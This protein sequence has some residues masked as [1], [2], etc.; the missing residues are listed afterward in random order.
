[1]NIVELLQI[2]NDSRPA[3]TSSRGIMSY[4]EMQ[5]CA[6]R[7]ASIIE[8]LRPKCVALYLDNCF[9]WVV[10]DLAAHLCNIPIVP[11]P[12]FFSQAQLIHLI[13]D[14]GA[15]LLITH[16][17]L[18]KQP[19]LSLFQEQPIEKY[20]S[21]F[22]I[23]QRTIFEDTHYPDGL[24]KITYTSGSTGTPKGVCLNSP[25]QLNVANSLS[26]VLQLLEIKKHLCV[27]PLS[28]LLENIAGVWAPLS[29]GASIAVPFLAELGFEGASRLNPQQFLSAIEKYDPESLILVPELLKVL[30]SG[31]ES[32][33]PIPSSLKF[34]AVGGANVSVPMLERAQALGLPVYEGYGLS[35][36]CSVVTLNRPSQNKIGTSGKV[37]PHVKVRISN[38]NEIEVS[39]SNMLGYLHQD[40]PTPEFYPTGDLGEIDSEGYVTIHGRKKNMFITS[41]GR[42]VNPEWLE[43]ALL[44]HKQLSQAVVFGESLPFNIAVIVLSDKD[45]D[46]ESI[47]TL[48]EQ[49]NQALPNYAKVSRYL[50]AH[51]PFSCESGTLATNGRLKRTKI[52]EIYRNEIQSLIE[53]QSKLS[54]WAAVI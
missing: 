34:I 7:Y 6:Y 3:L 53:A 51:S 43:Q 16:H 26:E 41:Y 39:G 23:Y 37:L 14:V 29:I 22:E 13:E 48:I 2:P 49:S 33:F 50:I 31:Y 35:E 10:A 52:W 30:V 32:G 4:E 18:H 12:T 19:V 54:H 42:Q 24:T 8:E 46:D 45:V 44:E 47:E 9:E 1:M 20:D 21:G 38:D 5:S 40:E 15:D 17:Q 11:L 27:L 25:A 36:C 28:T